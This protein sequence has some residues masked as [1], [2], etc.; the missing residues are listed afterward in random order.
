MSMPICD[1]LLG[2]SLVRVVLYIGYPLIG[3]RNCG[4]EIRHTDNA[5]KLAT[6]NNITYKPSP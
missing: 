3:I 5:A 4:K 1:A 2:L 6:S